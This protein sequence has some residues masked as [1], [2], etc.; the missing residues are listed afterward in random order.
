M[1]V[2]TATDAEQ[3]AYEKLVNAA[4]DFVESAKPTGAVSI[5]SLTTIQGDA[6]AW[7]SLSAACREVRRLMA[8]RRGR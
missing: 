7:G 5:R 2:D 1:S 8:A 6:I 3:V 4:L